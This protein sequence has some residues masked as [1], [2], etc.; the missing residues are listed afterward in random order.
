MSQNNAPST[1]M[2]P[3]TPPT[4]SARKKWRITRRGFLIGAGVVGSGVA[5]GY[6]FG[7][8][9]LHLTMAEM[10]DGGGGPPSSISTEPMAWIE[11]AP[12]NRATFHI[13]KI[14]MG[15][16]VHTA[17]AQILA[18]EL[19]ID[20]ANINVVH[21]NTIRGPID[22]SGTTGSTTV[23]SMYPV[24]REVAANMRE[25]LRAEAATQLV[26][27]VADLI[28]THGTITTK[29]KGASRTYGEIIVAKRGKWD[30]PKDKPVLKPVSEFKLIGKSLQRVDLPDKIIGEAIYGY[31]VRVPNM[32]YGAFA[33]PPTIGATLKGA[34]AGT[35]GSMPGVVKIVIEKDFVGV[36]AESRQAAR[37][38]IDALQV[39]W[40]A[41]KPLQQADIDAMLAVREGQGTI[42][43]NEGDAQK[44]LA[45]RSL[46][47]L[48]ANYN[49]PFAAHAHL[50]PQAALA[51][52]QADKAR[53]WVS[54]QMPSLVR[55][56][57]VTLLGMKEEQIEINPAYVGG[58]FGR[59]VGSD[60]AMPAARLSKAVG[61]PVH[62]GWV[63]QEEFQNGYLRPPTAHVLKAALSADGQISAL[64]HQQSS[65]E[66]AAAFLPPVMMAVFG[67][68]FGAWR[69]ARIHYG[70]PNRRTVARVVKLPVKTGWWR[71]LGLLAN[72]FAIESFIDELAA[73]VKMDPLAF[74]LKN[75]GATEEGERFRNVLNTVADKAGWGSPM[76][77]GHARG[78]ACCT[79]GKTI[80]AQV[81]EVSVTN[82]K[83]R[84]HKVHCVIEPGLVINPDGVK[85]QSE[86]AITMG[87]SSTL[88]EEARIEDGKVNARNFD[89]Y[90]LITMR[91]T[92]EIEVT[93]I[94]RGETPLGVGEPPIGPVAA[95]VANAVFALTGQRLRSLPLKLA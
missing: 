28:A 19:E 54:T 33:H 44:V 1:P 39:E 10:L 82:K 21:A 92:P 11:V 83:I 87:L 69:G 75:L 55:G 5:L 53:I 27:P 9:A 2:T 68:D 13:P 37:N 34:T 3:I 31:D 64:E 8:P 46:P 36:A 16:G 45:A 81:A 42:I 24:L 43:Q 25:M 76:P 62:V 74:R 73:S 91:D 29:D 65:G 56:E 51:D 94:S 32:L 71:G 18:E 52:V 4:K 90:P 60:A 88:F 84:V 86:G 15:Q 63:R 35:V 12:D 85:A 70:M 22:G 58:G 72:I 23:S 47:L 41:V 57:M 67:S 17:L 48:Q 49:T 95:A 61:R 30:V 59:K 79:D 78:I 14:E 26:K 7:R 77:D 40:N 6:V 50:E 89:A 93:V 80:V 20:W 38:A 66:V